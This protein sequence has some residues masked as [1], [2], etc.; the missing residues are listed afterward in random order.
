MCQQCPRVHTA[1]PEVSSHLLSPRNHSIVSPSKGQ[2]GRGER[3]GVVTS[4]EIVDA[5]KFSTINHC[6][7]KKVSLEFVIVYYKVCNGPLILTPTKTA[8]Y[9]ISP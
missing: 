6:A 1:K 8:L 9:Y 4:T 5:S 3:P 2:P 7:F